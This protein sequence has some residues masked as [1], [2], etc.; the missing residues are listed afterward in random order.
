MKHLA[1]YGTT[2]DHPT[3]CNGESVPMTYL[4]PSPE[5]PVHGHSV[6]PPRFIVTE[7]SGTK[8][9]SPICRVEP[10]LVSP[11]ILLCDCDGHDGVLFNKNVE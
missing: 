8:A 2:G 5:N 11:R 1:D 9:Q 6:K 7:G 3:S 4:F 10:F